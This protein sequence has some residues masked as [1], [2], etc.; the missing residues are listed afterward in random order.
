MT[1]TAIVFLVLAALLVWGGL[2]ASIVALVRRPEADYP[3]GGD[4]DDRLE[5]TVVEH[6]T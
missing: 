6:D 2:I 1:A 4:R 5:H 3:T